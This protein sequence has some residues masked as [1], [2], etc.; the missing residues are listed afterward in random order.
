MEKTKEYITFLY[1]KYFCKSHLCKGHP[2]D[3]GKHYLLPF[4]WIRVLLVLLQP[5][6]QGTGGLSG[7]VFTSCSSFRAGISEPSG[8]RKQQQ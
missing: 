7:G 1:I 6:L 3:D 2:G 8:N 4:G 5:S